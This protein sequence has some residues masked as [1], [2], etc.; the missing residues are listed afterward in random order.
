MLAPLPLLTRF[1]RRS[2]GTGWL[3]ALLIMLKLVIATGCLANDA[4]TAPLAAVPVAALAADMASV[5]VTVAADTATC[6]HTDAGD[7]HCHCAHTLPLASAASMRGVLLWSASTFVATLP[8]VVSPPT[9]NELRP[10]IA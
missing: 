2:R 5:D 1:R 10:P 6:W 9:Q 7:C 4:V 8:A 3:C